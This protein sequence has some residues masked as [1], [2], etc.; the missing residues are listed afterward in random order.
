MSQQNTTNSSTT[1]KKSRTTRKTDVVETTGHSWDGIEEL[2]NPLPRW[3]VWAFY[4]TAVFTV[5]YW[6]FYPAWPIGSSYTKGVPGLNTITYTAT[7]VDG[8]EVE[9]TTHWNMRSKFMVEMNE[10]QAAQKQWFDK[11]AATPFED[12]AKDAELMQFV[13]SAGKTLFSDNCAPCHQAGGQGVIGFAPNLTDDHWQY[14]YSYEAIQETIVHGRRGY[15]PPFKEIISDEEITQTANYVLSMSGEPHDADSAALGAKL[16]QTDKA[17]CYAC[18]GVDAKGIE[19]LGSAN[20]TDKIWLWANIPEIKEP[21]EKLKAVRTI[22]AGGL[23]RGVM[24]P[25]EDRLKP[26]QIKLLTVY[27]HQGLGGGK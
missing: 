26:D 24:P 18:H 17:A 27:V 3:W 8:T 11:V 12:I 5:V 9:I 22:I 10:L 2:N 19:G 23:N 21:E 13:T 6:L 14:G 25:W 7:Q 1:A 4:I 15:M 16:F 20:L